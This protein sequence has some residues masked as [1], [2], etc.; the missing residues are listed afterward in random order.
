MDELFEQDKYNLMQ[1]S[2]DDQDMKINDEDYTNSNL[3][4]EGVLASSK[5]MDPFADYDEVKEEE[6]PTSSKS[7]EGIQSNMASIFQKHRKDEGL[8]KGKKDSKKMEEDDDD[9]TFAFPMHSP[10]RKQAR[11]QWPISDQNNK[12][13]PKRKT[14]KQ[15]QEQDDDYIDDDDDFDIADPPPTK[16]RK[17]ASNNKKNIFGLSNTRKETPQA[18]T[19][20][21]HTGSTSSSTTRKHD[22]VK[23]WRKKFI[24]QWVSRYHGH[25]L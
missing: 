9:D 13:S 20:D 2:D 19:F 8:Y 23:E 21:L 3:T 24:T 7:M 18:K 12:Q 1:I 10:P 5:V 15:Q 22:A 17:T 14:R 4:G 25:V 11:N 16:A 6:T